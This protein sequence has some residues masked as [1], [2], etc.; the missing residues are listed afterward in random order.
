MTTNKTITH[1]VFIHADK[2][3]GI[4]KVGEPVLF[5]EYDDADQALIAGHNEVKAHEAG[6]LYYRIKRTEHAPIEPIDSVYEV[7]ALLDAGMGNHGI[8][9]T[10]QV[11]YKRTNDKDAVQSLMIE[12]LHSVPNAISADYVC[13]NQ[14]VR[15]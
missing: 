11:F 3:A 4:Y 12:A 15:V 2:D 14:G 8:H 13:L 1:Q 7:F 9:R 5:G 10:K 6:S